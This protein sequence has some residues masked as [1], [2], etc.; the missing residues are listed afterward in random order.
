M[1]KVT[2]TLGVLLLALTLCACSTSTIDI[3]IATFHPDTVALMR[4][5]ER[6][7]ACAEELFRQTG[8]AL[9][10][11]KS[12]QTPDRWAVVRSA[13]A[14]FDVRQCSQSPRF[15]DVV[16]LGQRIL[17]SVEPPRPRGMAAP[18]A[19]PDFDRVDEEAVKELERKVKELKRR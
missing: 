3:L 1:R 10:A 14:Q 19:K 5:P 4:L 15:V 8:D 7:R 18:D 11:Y 16:T 13:A 17:A 6:E 9:R 2:P 12:Q